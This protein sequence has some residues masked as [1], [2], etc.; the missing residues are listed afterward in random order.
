[1][2]HTPNPDFERLRRAIRREG[3]LER[4]PLLELFADP[5]IIANMMNVRYAPPADQ[6]ERERWTEIVVQFWYRLGY[7]AVRLGVGL[8][9]PH[10]TIPAADTA[11][12]QR[13]QR[14]WQ[15]D[16]EGL[17][18]TWDDYERYPWPD[19]DAADFTA[20]EHAARILPEG[21]KLLIS[22][23][24][25]LEPLMWIMGYQPFALALYDQPDLI[26]AMVER[27]AAIYV[28]ITERVLQMDAVGGLFVG[29]DMGFK[30]A[31]M[32]APDHLRRY[33]F[34]YHKRLVEM[35]HAA[36]KIY[37]L[38]AC[39]NLETVMDDLIDDVGIDAKHSFEDVILPVEQFKA[40][41][42]ERVG[43]VGGID[44]DFLCRASADQVR[45]RVNAVLDACMP[46]GGYVLGTGNSVANYVPVPNFLAMVDAGHRWPAHP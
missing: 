24:G 19:A 30:T 1:M 8:D 41:Y 12:L 6:L 29:D 10:K 36:G 16:H 39:G 20:I 17:I 3:E 43:V 14:D 22:P 40:R 46:G 13:A 11:R 37:V 25:M 7:D 34:P 5:E 38:H 32:I 9:P 45:D 26:A 31:T 4:V 18:A 33:V 2:M 42:G 21:M 35:T 27:I 28:P 44:M 23:Y 15:N